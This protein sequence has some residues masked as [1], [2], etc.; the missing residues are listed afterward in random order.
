VVLRIDADL[1]LALAEMEHQRPYKLCVRCEG[2]PPRAGLG[3]MTTVPPVQRPFLFAQH[4]QP[5]PAQLQCETLR[6]L[7]RKTSAEA[8]RLAGNQT[9]MAASVADIVAASTE[10]L[11][12]ALRNMSRGGGGLN[13]W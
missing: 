4:R 13:A 12:Q 6:E 5:Q 3:G 10:P 8:M 1:E 7:L 2:E 9:D 11:V